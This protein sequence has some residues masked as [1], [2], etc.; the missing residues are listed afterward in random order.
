MS[1]IS[2]GASLK[3]PV[4]MP[5]GGSLLIPVTFPEIQRGRLCVKPALSGMD[6]AST[7]LKIRPLLSAGQNLLI[8]NEINSGL[9]GAVMI[10][11]TLGGSGPKASLNICTP[12][13]L[14]GYRGAVRIA[15][16][17][18]TAVSIS[19]TLTVYG[20]GADIT[21]SLLNAEISLFNGSENCSVTAEFKP[22][23]RVP[24]NL[25]I[26]INSEEYSF[27]TISAVSTENQTHITAEIQMPETYVSMDGGYMRA[28][29]L[30]A[31]AGIIWAADGFVT[32]GITGEFTGFQLAALLAEQSGA[33]VRVMGG[34][35][36]LVYGFTGPAVY[37]PQNILHFKKRTTG[38]KYSALEITYGKSGDSYISIVPSVKKTHAGSSISLRVYGQGEKRVTAD[39]ASLVKTKAGITETV[40]EDITFQSGAG[41]LSKP[42]L[43][44]LTPGVTADGKTAACGEL[45][46]VK[47]VS[48]KTVCDIYSVTSG[49]PGQAAVFAGAGNTAV[50]L[51][52][53]GGP[54]KAIKT[55]YICDHVT[56][57]R[58]GR[59]FLQ[60]NAAVSE[61]TAAHSGALNTP[62][63][64][65]VR[66]AYCEGPIKSAKIRIENNPV[67]ITDILEV[68]TWQR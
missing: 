51:T 10:S 46:G 41:R 50:V 64:I 57:V 12:L 43:A 14:A 15:L 17:G 67:K 23:L 25:N 59:A 28:S 22:L 20:D 45:T 27:E 2:Y 21:G 30:A 58:R 26:W 54:V 1:S 29:A 65:A 47:S 60:K 52:G 39:G 53:T 31:D 6:E 35:S 56:A 63:A 34:G 4:V 40:T 61:I 66:S 9:K 44:V 62:S 38:E 24:D 5:E 49:T 55:P 7:A 33:G 68:L 3:I 13:C 37:E 8:R 19:D 18:S 36:P 42:A 11:G 16:P 48:Y 32:G